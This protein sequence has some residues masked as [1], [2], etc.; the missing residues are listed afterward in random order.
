MTPL[1]EQ[2][3]Q[4]LAWMLLFPPD[5]V[6]KKIATSYHAMQPKREVINVKPAKN[7][8]PR[9]SELPFIQFFSV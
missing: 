5:P 1:E 4:L 7:Q 2:R 3:K 8:R 9:Q 6:L